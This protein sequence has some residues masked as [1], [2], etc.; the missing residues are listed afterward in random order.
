MQSIADL[1]RREIKRSGETL[2]AI[3]RDAGVLQPRL[4]RFVNEGSDLMLDSIEKLL[5]YFGYVVVK[6]G[7]T[8]TR[9]TAP[10]SAGKPRL[11]RRPPLR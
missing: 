11:K 7:S 3:A 4:W 6:K 10:K 1:L 8:A 2:S 9:R 5:D